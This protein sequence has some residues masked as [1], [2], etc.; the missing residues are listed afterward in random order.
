VI[1]AS[2]Q[3][4]QWSTSPFSLTGLNGY[5][6]GRGAS[7]NKG[8]VLAVASAAA[9]L[10]SQDLLDVDVVCLVE[11][12]E[13]AGSGGFVECVRANKVCVFCPFGCYDVMC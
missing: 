3:P 7:D 1:S 2:T 8:P 11:G 5:L 4:N 9:E 10:L 12:E 13:E 6:Y